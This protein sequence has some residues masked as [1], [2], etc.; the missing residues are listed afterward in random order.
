VKA[1]IFDWDGTLVDT[2]GALYRANVAVLE[3]FGLP[4][5]EVLYRRH[6]APDWRVMYGRLGIPPEQLDEANE[7]W[8]SHYDGGVG[9]APFAGVD[10]ALRR[11]AAQGSSLGLVTAGHRSVVEP[12]LQSTGLG[13]LLPVRVF[14]D[15]LPVHKPDPEPLR[16]AL[17]RVG[18]AGD[19]AEAVYVGDAPDDMRMAAAV[20]VR[21]VGIASLLGDPDELRSAGAGTVASSVPA[22]VDEALGPGAVAAP[23]P[24]PPSRSDRG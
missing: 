16:A 11:L 14:G 2:L 1:V 7:R 18:L 4:F 21:A 9:L 24:G 3:G 13:A 10:D 22:W 23:A 19:P 5:D 6:Y 8:L 20:G 15:D 17:R 12:Q